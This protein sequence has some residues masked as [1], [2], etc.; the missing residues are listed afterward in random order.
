MDVAELY[1]F[2]YETDIQQRIGTR[3]CYQWSMARHHKIRKSYLT[4]TSHP[5]C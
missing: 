4:S 3:L 5:F 2:R 1:G